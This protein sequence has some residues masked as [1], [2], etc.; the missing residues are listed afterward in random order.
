[1]NH[2][3]ALFAASVSSSVLLAVVN[4]VRKKNTTMKIRT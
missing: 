4:Q 2:M 3:I 1:M